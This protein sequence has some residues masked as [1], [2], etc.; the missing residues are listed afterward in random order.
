MWNLGEVRKVAIFA[1][2]SLPTSK[3]SAMA[4]FVA[5]VTVF[6]AILLL[7]LPQ[8]DAFSSPTTSTRV[9]LEE[10]V[11][12]ME[13]VMT[14]DFFESSSSLSTLYAQSCKSV[15]I[16]ESSIPGAGLGLFAKKNVKANT[17]ICFYPA[18]ALGVD[19]DDSNNE[20][21]FVCNESDKE[22]FQTHPSSQSTYLHCTDQPLF[23]RPSLLQQANG[24][25]QADTPLYLDANPNRP[26]EPAWVS[27][28]INDG[29]TVQT[30]TEE[31]VL[32]YYQATKQCK[33]C[34]HIPFGPSPIMVTVTTRKV[35]KGQEFLTSYGATYWLGVLLDVHGQEGVGVTSKIQAQIQE[36][37]MDLSSSMQSVAVVYAN[38]LEALQA[39]FDKI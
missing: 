25:D 33:N 7:Y 3:L 6:S 8:S 35:K 5:A 34:I 13:Q 14:R 28:M 1:S 18:H 9:V 27:Q 31:G 26:I 4:P 15:E 21:G 16:K 19:M 29:A 24:L 39:E 12:K 20:G 30:N 11:A 2:T 17:V 10:G 23:K 38:Q 37:A 36:T 22:Y 32:D